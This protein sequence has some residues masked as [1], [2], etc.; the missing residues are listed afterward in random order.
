MKN[1]VKGGSAHETSL[2]E[3]GV[4]LGEGVEVLQYAVLRTG[5]RIG[6][7]TR[8]CSHVYVDSKVKIGAG[9]KIKNGVLVYN[10]VTIKDNVFVGPG[11]VFT[12][13]PKPRADRKHGEPYPQ[14][15][16]EEGASI[17]ANATILPGIRIGRNAV[18]GA[19]SVVT[20]NVLS[21]ETVYGNP[22]S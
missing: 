5:C 9:C 10:G 19:G 6:D 2:V 15:I 22:A 13:D 17:G 18:I 3:W 11:V 16:V 20:K 14:T 7:N 8:I 12:N 1:L 21:G 4:I